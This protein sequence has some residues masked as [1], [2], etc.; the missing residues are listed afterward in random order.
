MAEL[1]PRTVVITNGKTEKEISGSAWN[2]LRSSK[3]KGNTRKGWT[4][5]RFSE[6]KSRKVATPATAVTLGVSTY[7][8]PEVAAAATVAAAEATMLAGQTVTVDEVLASQGQLTP[9]P[10]GAAPSGPATSDV[11][12]APVGAAQAAAPAQADAPPAGEKAAEALAETYTG[13]KD[14]LQK[15]KN[16]GPKTEQ[17]LNSIG[18]YTYAHLRDAD[19]AA[20]ATVLDANGLGVKKALIP[21]WKK[22]AGDIL[23]PPT[24]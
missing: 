1:D 24:E 14:D 13:P 17:V 5:V 9:D 2:L 20:V 16:V 21:H 23:N 12:A 8:P 11:P 4:F 15:V 19:D 10:N 7:I 6:P 22:G 18:I 3:E